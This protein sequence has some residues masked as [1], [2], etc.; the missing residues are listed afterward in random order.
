MKKFLGG[1]LFWFLFSWE[2]KI[3]RAPFFVGFIGVL[4]IPAFCFIGLPVLAA[5]LG[6][7]DRVVALSAFPGL[8]MLLSLTVFWSA[9]IVKRLNDLG[10]SWLFG[11]FI[12]VPYLNIL[13]FLYLCFKKPVPAPPPP[14]PSPSPPDPERPELSAAELKAAMKERLKK[15]AAYRTF[16][17]GFFRE[18]FAALRDAFLLGIALQEKEDQEKEDRRR[19]R[20]ETG[21]FS[22]GFE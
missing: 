2:G 13:F 7:P 20:K 11:L 10:R 5:L 17:P 1:K 9:L 6:F 12:L 15:K 14:L 8:A 21:A 18:N 19:R 3:K 4:L 16:S 22:K